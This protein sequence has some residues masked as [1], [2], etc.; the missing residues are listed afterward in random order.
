MADNDFDDIR[1]SRN[2]RMRELYR[3]HRATENAS[4]LKTKMDH[5]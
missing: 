2:A 5:Q 4:R 1:Q 3:I